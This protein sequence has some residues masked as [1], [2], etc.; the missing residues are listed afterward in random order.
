MCCENCGQQRQ[1]PGS[2]FFSLPENQI[3]HDERIFGEIGFRKLSFNGRGKRR[4]APAL[5]H[6]SCPSH[7]LI[8]FAGN[9][10]EGRPYSKVLPTPTSSITVNAGLSELLVSAVVPHARVSGVAEDTM[11]VIT[12]AAATLLILA[13]AVFTLHKAVEPA[14]PQA[15][16][17]T[18]FGTPTPLAQAPP[19]SDQGTST[20][21]VPPSSFMTPWPDL[22]DLTTSVSTADPVASGPAE[23]ASSAPP[24]VASEK[25]SQSNAHSA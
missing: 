5:G 13:L 19:N 17:G 23:P 15:A 14:P 4:Q 1:L 22:E 2:R 10:Q 11:L 7:V 8:W 12:Q 18:K 9:S 21:A 24:A 6:P 3:V 25:A 20:S 16:V